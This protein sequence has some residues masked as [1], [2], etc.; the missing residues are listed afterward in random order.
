MI[1]PPKT[2][3][4]IS[5]FHRWLHLSSRSPSFPRCL[6]GKTPENAQPACVFFLLIGQSSNVFRCVL[7]GWSCCKRRT[8]DFSDFLSIVVSSLFQPNGFLC[9][10]LCGVVS[11]VYCFMAIDCHLCQGH[12]NLNI[13]LFFFES[14]TQ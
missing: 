10:I 12:N 13:L 8:T 1:S 5:F 2:S 6:E 3:S 7:Q 9:S 11:I 4:K 14:P